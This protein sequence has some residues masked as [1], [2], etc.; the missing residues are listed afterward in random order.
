MGKASRVQK[1]KTN[2]LEEE[3]MKVKK[4]N[5]K[6]LCENDVLQGELT[7][8]RN[9]L[10]V[11][12]RNFLN[13][14]SV[15]INANEELEQEIKFFDDIKNRNKDLEEKLK[16][17]DDVEKKNKASEEQVKKLEEENSMMKMELFNLKQ[18]SRNLKF[19]PSLCDVSCD[20][21]DLSLCDEKQFADLVCYDN[22]NIGLKIMERMGFKGK[23]L[24]KH[25][26]GIRSPIKPT[27]RPK[28]EGLG[29]ATENGKMN[30]GSRESN[31]SI[32][33][34]QC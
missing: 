11:E 15:Y 22:N 25:E 21:N 13:Q 9:E 28:Y 31:E 19:N 14:T 3:L 34:V 26:Q 8:L 5:V 6:L 10:S 23:G 12:G 1:E 18:E 20:T 2:N 7:K 16:V 4:E 24:G 33:I 17:F 30:K 32:K 27:I 29:Y